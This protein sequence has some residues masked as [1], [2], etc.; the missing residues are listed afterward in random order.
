[1]ACLCMCV[2]SVLNAFSQVNDSIGAGEDIIEGIVENESNLE[3]GL[4]GYEQALEALIKHPI[5]INKSTYYDLIQTGLFTDVQCRNLLQHREAYGPLLN[6]YELQTIPFFETEDIKRLSSFITTGNQSQSNTSFLQQLYSG[7][8]QYYLRLSKVLEEQDGYNGDTS[9]SSPYPGN[10]MRIYTRLKY[11]FNNQLMYGITAEKDP[12]EEL[13]G[14]TQP[15]GFDFYSA[16]FYKKSNGYLN[17][18]ALG[19]YEINLGQGL[20]LW[21]GFG[22][23]KSVYPL[24]VRRTAKVLD[25]YSSVDENRFMRGAAV[26]LGKK[27][28]FITP[29]ISSKKID[30]NI[31]LFDTV[32]TEVLEVSSLQTSGLHR[33]ESELA[34]KH[35]IR[36]TIAGIDISYYQQQF[37]IGASA[38]YYHFNTDLQKENTPYQ[39]YDFEGNQLLHSGVHYHYLWKNILFYGETALSNNLQEGESFHIASLNGLL[40]PLDKTVDLA[41]VYR[42]F[43][44]AYQ[45]L[46]ANAFADASSPSN[47]TGTYFGVEIKPVRAWKI[48]GYIDVY[49]H[50]WLEFTADA[51]SY[52]TDILAEINFKPTKTF[53]TYLRLKNEI[54]NQNLSSDFS[55]DLPYDILIDRTKRSVRW[56]LV[57]KINSSFTLQNRIEY[58]LYEQATTDVQEKGYLVYQDIK[59]HPFEFPASLSFRFELF[60]TDSYNSRIYTYENDVLYAYSIVALYGRGTRNYVTLEYSPFRWL[61]IWL[62]YARTFYDNEEIPSNADIEG[63]S[64]SDGRV[65]IRLK[66]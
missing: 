60:N 63:P 11:N 37:S 9:V 36:Q 22:Y 62:R 8:Y 7:K 23:G 45:T 40:I 12:G 32:D 10:N 57:Y 14:D 56:N 64:K 42:N 65:Q 18:I 51:P 30:A 16:H 66:W 17:T 19:D 15:Q 5:N 13:F 6:I 35:A 48:A 52:G 33:T 21:S 3:S 50:P 38:V 29:F 43:N 1:M 44:K 24:A 25:V 28:L 20:M 59:Y 47:E 53:E 49:K 55:E 46:Y 4:E 34:D 41:I 2:F 39:F 26:T 58:A 27:H 31:T 54:S 61:D